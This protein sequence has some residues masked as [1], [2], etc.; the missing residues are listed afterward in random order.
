[1]SHLGLGVMIKM[2][3]GGERVSALIESFGKTIKSA[4]LG[5]EDL[6]L[7][8]ED[9]A[10][11]RIWDGGQSC[12]ESRYMRTDDDLSSFAGAKLVGAELS[13]VE[14]H[15]DQENYCTHEMQFLR[16]STDRGT[17]VVSTHNEHNGY[18]GGF[19]LQAEAV[20]VPSDGSAP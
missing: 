9:G 12:C 13:D 15:E 10:E 20:S 17:I 14:S 6:R 8:F 11:I 3:G 2:L 5:E 4:A 18:Y 16:L 7:T 19:W 1:V